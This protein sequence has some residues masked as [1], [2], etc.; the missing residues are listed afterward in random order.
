MKWFNSNLAHNA[1]NIAIALLA[2]PEFIGFDWTLFGLGEDTSL[3]IAGGLSLLK[4]V[5]NAW[6]DGPS[7]MVAPQPPVEK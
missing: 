7:G 1:M 6:R 2:A 4:L 5:I 3:K